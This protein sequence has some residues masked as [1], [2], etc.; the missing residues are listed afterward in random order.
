M[1]PVLAGYVSLA[2]INFAHITEIMQF[3]I[4]AGTIAYQIIYLLKKYKNK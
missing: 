2:A 4:A 1:K 3:I